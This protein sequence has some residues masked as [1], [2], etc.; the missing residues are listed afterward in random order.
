MARARNI[1]PGFFSNDKLAE[2]PPLG[3]ILFAGLWTIADRKG[4]L[5]DRPKKVKAEILPYDGCN[6]DKLLDELQSRAFILRYEC[7]GVRYIQVLNFEKHQN[8]HTKEA[9][10]TIPAP[11]SPGAKPVLAPKKADTS[12]ADSGF[13]IPDSLNLIPD[14]TTDSSIAAG[15]ANA[16]AKPPAKVNGTAKEE[17]KP[18]VPVTQAV[19]TAYA[20]AYKA[21]YG[22]DPVRNAKV[23]GQLA[24]LLQ[25]LSAAEAPAVAASYV[26]HNKSLYVSSKHCVDLLLRDCEGLRTEWATGK[27]V[28]DTEA[29]QMDRKQNNL[30]IA[31]KL[32][33]EARANA[34]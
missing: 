14:S 30:G 34:K 25:R 3:R 24:Q 20:F 2:L 16:D 10:S 12:R 6:V 21:R 17:K 23:N 18:D 11:D 22:V 28:T 27:T 1:K 32:I 7:G 19:W 8:P 4:R 29:R 26:H 15:S 9:D 31:E 13:L 33:A 5:E